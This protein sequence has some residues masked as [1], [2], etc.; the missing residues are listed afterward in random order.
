MKLVTVGADKTI[1]VW[2]ILNG[3]L[4]HKY[5]KIKDKYK[6]QISIA[7]Y[8]GHSI[9]GPNSILIASRGHQLLMLDT[10]MFTR[11]KP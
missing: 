7:S 6:R 10:E 8:W 11:P 4:I 5:T 1:A 3:N 9:G 2:N